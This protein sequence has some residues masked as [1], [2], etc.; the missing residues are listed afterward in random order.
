M[1]VTKEADAQIEIFEPVLGEIVADDSF[2]FTL[3]SCHCS[4]GG[5]ELNN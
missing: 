2:A 4:G 5:I 1:E 3:L